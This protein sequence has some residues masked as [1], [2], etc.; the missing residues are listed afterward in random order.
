TRLELLQELMQ[1]M[2]NESV[3]VSDGEAR[4]A[5]DQ[6]N[7][8]LALAYVEFPYSGLLSAMA[9]TDKQVADYYKGHREEF[10]EPERIQF[11][12]VRYNPDRMAAKFTPSD[13]EIQ[14]YYERSRDTKFT[15]PEQVHARHI[16]IAVPPDATPQQKAAAKAKADDL[17]KQIKAGADFAKLA[18]E[19]SDDPGTK[20]NGGDLGYFSQGEMIKPFSEAAFKM[21]PGE[22]TVVETKYGYH[23]IRVED[24]KLA[25]VETPAE[26]RPRIVE[27]LRHR[28]GADAARQ[29]I[30]QDLAAALAGK[31]LKELAEKRGLSVARTPFLAV[32][33]HVPEIQDPRM[34]REAFKLQPNDIRVIN[35]RQNSFLIKLL[36]RQPSYI[37]KLADIQ[38]KVR[39][40]LARQMAETKAREQAAAFLKQVKDPAGLATAAAAAKLQVRTTGDFSR[41]DN[42][43]P[44]IGE[45][46]E[47]ISETA[48]LSK[49]PGVVNRPVVLGGNAYVFEVASRAA[50]SDA[51]W[52]AA[53]DAFVA[54]LLKQR[55]F[56]AWKGF[57]ETLRA[58]AQIVVHPDLIG[59]PAESS[60]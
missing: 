20:N 8:K 51:Q 60:M 37:P 26:A 24:H 54:Q 42:S 15:H 28:A 46:P 21:R 58:R 57:L 27:A 36:A 11:D 17:L 22:M 35:G 44:T 41:A 7:L 56:E 1:R 32:G 12:F 39:A 13:K 55:Q 19:F 31:G 16:L 9:P 4:Q 48:M 40:A 34:M 38:A 33:E 14:D 43:I 3:E 18:Q 45:F 30:D 23:I 5:Y 6:Q 53:K 25:Y 29:A 10:R 50:P 59:Q 52:K 47:A 2:I 49:V